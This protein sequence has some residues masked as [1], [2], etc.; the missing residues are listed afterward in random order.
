MAT[1]HRS[2]LENSDLYAAL[3][4][5]HGKVIPIRAA[6]RLCRQH[7][8]DVYAMVTDGDIGMRPD[9]DIDTLS[10]VQGLGY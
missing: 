10:L 5:A 2:Y 9:G 3:Y 6:E 7:G 8:H 1:Q 4:E